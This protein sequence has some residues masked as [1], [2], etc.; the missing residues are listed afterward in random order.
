MLSAAAIHAQAPAGTRAAGRTGSTA[1]AGDE[2][3]LRA[4]PRVAC[5]TTA[6]PKGELRGPFVLPSQAY[7]GTQHTYWLHVPAQY[8]PGVPASLMIFQ[9]GQAFKDM[10]GSVRAPQRARQPDLPARNPGDDH[11]LHQSRPDARAAGADAERVG[12]SHDEP[13]DRIQHARR[14]V[15]A[16][17]CGRA[18]AG[19]LQGLQHLE[20]SRPARHRR[21]QLRRDCRVHRRMA[22]AGRLPQSA[23]HRWKLRQPAR[24]R[25]LS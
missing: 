14:Q 17:H 20:R 22:A 7:P 4:R 10:D 8:D 9:D 13:A 25:R 18:V 2:R 15:R 12:R 16:G 6:I 19:A 3:V 5:R 24:R 1:G 11:G 21:R 23:Q